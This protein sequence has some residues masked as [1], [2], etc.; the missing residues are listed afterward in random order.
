MLTWPRITVVTPSYNQANF[1]D[2]TI[3]SVLDQNY[4]NLEYIVMDG[5]STDGSIEILKQY[6]SRLKWVSQPD[7]GQADAINKGMHRAT[8][9]I[10]CYLNSDDVL[11]LGSLRAVATAFSEN[12]DAYWVTGK[13]RIINQIDQPI[14]S[15]V[16]VYKSL[17]LGCYSRNALAITN[18]ICQP[19]T[20]WR[21]SAYRKVGYFDPSL[22][23]VMDYEFWL[24]LSVLSDPIV[25]RRSLAS[26]R[27]HA[28]SKG[29]SQYKKQLIEDYA[30]LTNH[31]SSLSLRVLHRLHN[32]AIYFAYRLIK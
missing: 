18:F 16:T 25:L 32:A 5:G 24:R 2:A 30:V 20:F 12:P 6:D 27:I 21:R 3:R 9:E 23:Y 31:V 13:C 8:G 17:W 7:K 14:R 29:E 15:F 1:L 26:F 22:G 28:N 11:E 10:V 4:P 19:A